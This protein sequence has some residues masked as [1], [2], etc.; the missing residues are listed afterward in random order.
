MD[1]KIL[2]KL[3]AKSI[4]IT[5]EGFGGTSDITAEMVAA[6]LS[7]LN[8]AAYLYAQ[9]KYVIMFDLRSVRGER[10]QDKIQTSA[11][12]FDRMPL[13][14][15]AMAADLVGAMY[16]KVIEEHVDWHNVDEGTLYHATKAALWE[17]IDPRFSMCRKCGGT[18]KNSWGSLTT[19]KPARDCKSC[20]G[21]GTIEKTATQYAELLG[22]HKSNWARCWERR[23][24]KI[25]MVMGDLDAQVAR[26]INRKF[27]D[28]VA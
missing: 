28:D 3:T 23:Y 17:S 1:A 16:E 2:S 5:G 26:H 14:H 22:I 21:R 15:K 7:G 8:Q 27:Q 25:L 18:G 4:R 12:Y 20:G 10:A 24:E 9:F 11:P 19:G 13:A 6:A